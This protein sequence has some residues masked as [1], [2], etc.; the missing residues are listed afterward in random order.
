MLRCLLLSSLVLAVA[1][2]HADEVSYRREVSALLSR[3]GCRRG[4]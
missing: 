2:L 3:G 1:P 4:P